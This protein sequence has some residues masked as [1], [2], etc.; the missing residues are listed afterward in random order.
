MRLLFWQELF[1][2][3][4]I[5][6]AEVMASQRLV[7]LAER[8]HEVAIVTRGNSPGLPAHERWQGLPIHRVPAAFPPVAGA[9]DGFLQA[10]ERVARLRRDFAPDVVHLNGLGPG[11]LLHALTSHVHPAPVVV[12][13]H[14]E[15]PEEALRTGSIAGNAL[16]S[17]EWIACVSRAV[18]AA[19]LRLVPEVRDRSSVVPNAL[20]PPVRPLVPL[21]FDPPHVLCLGRLVPE[22]GFDLALAAFAGLRGR[23]PR[24]RLTVAGDGPARPELERRAAELMPPDAVQFLGWVRPEQVPAL[25]EAATLVVVPSRWAEPFGLVA[26]EAAWMGR[27]VVA[28]RV[29]GL[30]EVVAHG[31][32]GLLV[33]REDEHALGLAI[34]ELLE[35]PRRAERMGEEARRHARSSFRFDRH[36]DAYEG[37]YRRVIRREAPAS[38]Q[39]C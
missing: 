30:P 15:W 22:K 9:R 7:V 24:A 26:L 27:P 32:T 31:R 21:P 3:P 20:K 39:P 14:R 28:A 4:Y 37:L 33:E 36:V 29:G 17:A 23:F 13:L 18:L 16:R 6:G 25:I 34:A 11:L 8:G 12:T 1:W 5:G 2:P 10:A 19:T 35:H 38:L